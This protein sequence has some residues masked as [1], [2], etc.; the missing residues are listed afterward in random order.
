MNGQ[1]ALKSELFTN[2][3]FTKII[4]CSIHLLLTYEE[5]ASASTDG[6]SWLYPNTD[7]FLPDFLEMMLRQYSISLGGNNAGNTSNCRNKN[8]KTIEKHSMFLAE[9]RKI[10][11]FDAY[12]LTLLKDF[13]RK[14][15][16]ALDA[17]N[18]M[19]KNFAKDKRLNLVKSMSLRLW[20]NERLLSS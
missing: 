11:N 4:S 6:Q 2:E 16:E 12:I 13:S 17:I 10:N 14:G 19:K 9:K 7:E 18:I 5:Q 15:F 3:I 8:F 20:Q 1:E